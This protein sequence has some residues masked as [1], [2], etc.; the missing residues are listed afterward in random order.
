MKGKFINGR[1]TV[2]ENI[3]DLGGAKLAFLAYREL[4]ESQ[5]KTYNA[6]GFSE[7]QQ[8]FLAHGQSWCSR[9]R[10]AELQR[11]LTVDTHSPPSW[12]I[13]GALRNMP[14]FAQAFSCAAGTPMRPAKACTVW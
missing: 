10:P 6:G 7:D 5:P 12:R 11:R 9:M 1:L 14:E 3:A 13:Y 2:S 4:R 8:F